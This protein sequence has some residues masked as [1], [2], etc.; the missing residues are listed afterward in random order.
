MTLQTSSCSSSS[1]SSPSPPSEWYAGP[2]APVIL[3][4]DENSGGRPSSSRAFLSTTPAPGSSIEVHTH[5]HEYQIWVKLPGF[6]W[7]GITLATQ[8]RR[9]LH[10][11]ADKWD[12]NGGKHLINF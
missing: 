11:V 5:A 9:V 7:D 2:D 4:E 10:I 3:P 6:S 8:K 12:N 1:S